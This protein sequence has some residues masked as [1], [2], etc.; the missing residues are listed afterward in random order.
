MP[1]LEQNFRLSRGDLIYGFE[2]PRKAAIMASTRLKRLYENGFWLTCNEYNDNTVLSFSQIYTPNSA[3]SEEDYWNHLKER[4][5]RYDQH[6]KAITS[7]KLTWEEVRQEMPPN[8][9][10]DF[11]DLVDEGQ[12]GYGLSQNQLVEGMAFAR[13]LHRD[14]RYKPETVKAKSEQQLRRKGDSLQF[15]MIRKSCKFGLK[16]V[17]QVLPQNSTVHFILDEFP[18]DEAVVKKEKHEG[19]ISIT[20]SELRWVF[21]EWPTIQNRVIFYLNS[22]QVTAPWNRNPEPWRR[23]AEERFEKY[24]KKLQ[25]RGIHDDVLQADIGGMRTNPLTQTTNNLKQRT[26]DLD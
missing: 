8:F 6:Y 5:E 2:A 18:T 9:M 16:Y 15:A 7:A 4:L 25:E 12:F 26:F 24:R 20:I 19:R 21:R 13:V 23:Y 11:A 10:R 17:T 1:T 22:T 3:A 14:R